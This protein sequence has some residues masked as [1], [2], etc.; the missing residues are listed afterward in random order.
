MNENPY[1]GSINFLL[2]D[3]GGFKSQITCA[4]SRISRDIY[5]NPL[6]FLESFTEYSVAHYKFA[7]MILEWWKAVDRMG[8]SPARCFSS[9]TND[10][11]DDDLCQ[12]WKIVALSVILHLQ[13]FYLSRSLYRNA[14]AAAALCNWRTCAGVIIQQSN[15]S[16][17]PFAIR[18]RRLF[19]S[20]IHFCVIHRNTN[21]HLLE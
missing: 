17:F 21:R 6:E 7:E 8:Q 11:C 20:S 3:F 2:V 15:L 19:Q 10:V 9:T 16:R 13:R 1:V 14:N 18:Q 5:C 4:T 12:P